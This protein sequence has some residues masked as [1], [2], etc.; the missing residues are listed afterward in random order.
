MKRHCISWGLAISILC[1]CGC[2]TFKSIRT[3]S[4]P[5]PHV[6]K[7]YHYRNLRHFMMLKSD[8]TFVV[9]QIDGDLGGN[10]QVQNNTLLLTLDREAISLI[11]RL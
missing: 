7:Y 5:P 8:G 10:Y 6:G 11:R 9:H 1:I 4:L 3:A 2:T